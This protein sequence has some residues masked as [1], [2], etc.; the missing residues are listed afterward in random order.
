MGE[1]GRQLA[2]YRREGVFAGQ[3]YRRQSIYGYMIG[4]HPISQPFALAMAR[5]ISGNGHVRTMQVVTPDLESHEDIPHGAAIRG[6]CRRCACGCGLV[7]MSS[8]HHYYDD[9]HL[10]LARN[11][12]RRK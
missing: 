12:R 5:L 6:Y 4:H 3:P 7:V 10:R 9:T 11:Q 1:L 8:A 2:T